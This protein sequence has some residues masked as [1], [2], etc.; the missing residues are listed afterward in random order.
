MPLSVS[1]AL[2][3]VHVAELLLFGGLTVAAAQRWRAQ[4]DRAGI[5]AAAT[6]G[7]VTLVVASSF[8]LDPASESDLASWIRKFLVAILLLF[9][10]CL[11]RYGAE[12]EKP[13]VTMRRLAVGL[14]VAVMGWTFLLGKLHGENAPRTTALTLFVVGVLVQWT[15]LSAWSARVLWRTGRGQATVA[16]NRMRTLALGLIVLNADLVVAATT[17]S[18]SGSA[19]PVFGG[20]IALLSGVLFFT[21]VAPPR[22][23]RSVWRTRDAQTLRSAEAHLMSALEPADIGNALLPSLASLFGGKGAVLVGLDGEI[24]ASSGLTAAEAKAAAI[25][26][27]QAGAE[28]VLESGLLAVPLRNGWLAVRGSVVTPFFGHEEIEILTSLGVFADLALDRVTLFGLERLARQ[29]AER[30]NTELETFVYSVSHDLKSPLVSLLGF[31]DY[32][33]AELNG[34]LSNEGRFFLERITASSMYMQAL[35][36]DLLEL[37]RI[38]RVQTETS[39]VD[40]GVILHD[41]TADLKATHRHANFVV[42]ELPV[43]DMNPLRARQLFTNLVANAVGHSGRD[44]VTVVI[45]SEVGPDGVVIRVADNGRGIPADYRDKVFGVFERLEGHDDAKG[46]GIGLAVCRKIAEQSGGRIELT[47]NHPGAC[48][49]VRF[50]AAIVRRGPAS[51]EVVR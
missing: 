44:D 24:I 9:P 47:D 25:V 10:Y 21:G 33:K 48:F 37:S 50:P 15:I 19:A 11:F 22:W 2:V 18:K 34:D 46:T 42:G 28:R 8:V 20:I 49:S 16:R 39:A 26:A 36:Q 23:L 14:T 31:L 1:S 29:Q 3:V 38:G 40:L 12:F 7:D 43:I 30:A 32:L 5:W 35:I 4:R 27:V 17:N 45:G 41:V 6:F 13:S 51:L